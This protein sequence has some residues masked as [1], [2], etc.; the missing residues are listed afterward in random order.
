MGRSQAAAWAKGTAAAA[1]ICPHFPPSV[2]ASIRHCSTSSGSNTGAAASSFAALLL[3]KHDVAEAPP[4]RLSAAAK[5]AASHPRID[6]EISGTEFL[7]LAR[8]CMLVCTGT[9][10]LFQDLWSAICKRAASM[11]KALRLRDAVLLLSAAARVQQLLRHDEHQQFSPQ[12]KQ[13]LLQHSRMVQVAVTALARGLLR[14][15]QHQQLAAK[16]HELQQ[17][18]EQDHERHALTAPLLTAALHAFAILKLQHPEALQQ[19]ASAAMSLQV[20]KFSGYDVTAFCS[21]LLLAARQQQDP[22]WSLDQL[23][24]VSLWLEETL[25]QQLQ[26]QNVAFQQKNARLMLQLETELQHHQKQQQQQQHP[27]SQQSITLAAQQITHGLQLL[28][29][30]SSQELA[31][32]WERLPNRQQINLS[33]LLHFFLV[34]RNKHRPSPLLPLMLQAALLQMKEA[35]LRLSL[36]GLKKSTGKPLY[37]DMQPLEHEQSPATDT[38]AAAAETNRVQP[39]AFSLSLSSCRD[40]AGLAASLQL[41]DQQELEAAETQLQLVEEQEQQVAL[42][43]SQAISLLLHRI[44]WNGVL[45]SFY[46]SIGNTED[47]AT[48]AHAA[49]LKATRAVAGGA[50]GT[51][52]KADANVAAAATTAAAALMAAPPIAQ[53]LLLAADHSALLFASGNNSSD[54]CNGGSTNNKG[55]RHHEF[56][57]AAQIANSSSKVYQRTAAARC[58]SVAVRPAAIPGKVHLPLAAVLQLNLQHHWSQLSPEQLAMCW[59]FFAQTAAAASTAAGE[60]DAAASPLENS[61]SR[62]SEYSSAKSFFEWQRAAG[63]L[64]ATLAVGPLRDGV[65]SKMPSVHLSHVAVYL[66]AIATLYNV[67]NNQRGAPIG[68]ASVAHDDSLSEFSGAPL[69][70]THLVKQLQETSEGLARRLMELLLQQKHHQL[71]PQQQQE[72]KD[73]VKAVVVGELLEGPV[74]GPRSLGHIITAVAALERMAP[75]SAAATVAAAARSLLQQKGQNNVPGAALSLKH[76]GV[77]LHALAKFQLRDTEILARLCRCMADPLEQLRQQLQQQQHP[78]D[79]QRL[80]LLSGQQVAQVLLSLSQLSFTPAHLLQSRGVHTPEQEDATVAFYQSMFQL[81]QRPLQYESLQRDMELHSAVNCLHALALSD[82][83]LTSSVVSCGI[84]SAKPWG[85]AGEEGSPVSAVSTF[86]DLLLTVVRKHLLPMVQQRQG[87][88]QHRQPREAESGYCTALKTT[89][90]QLPAVHQQLTA[91]AAAAAAPRHTSLCASLHPE[92]QVFLQKLQQHVCCISPSESSGSAQEP[93]SWL[94]VQGDS[95]SAAGAPPH[96]AQSQARLTVE[97]SASMQQE[98]HERWQEAVLIA[99]AKLLALFSE[100]AVRAAFAVAS[101]F[102][103]PTQARCSFGGYYLDILAELPGG[104]VQQR[105]VAVEADGGSHFLFD[106]SMPQ[107]RALRVQQHGEGHQPEG[108]WA[109]DRCGCI[110]SS[111][112]VLKHRLLRERGLFVVSVSAAEWKAAV[113]QSRICCWRKSCT[114]S[115]QSHALEASADQASV[116]L[117]SS[118][119]APQTVRQCHEKSGTGQ[120]NRLCFCTSVAF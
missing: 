52:A 72:K 80:L 119:P 99:D 94:L 81:L 107:P 91:A 40:L 22:G 113:R 34:L 1:L 70:H 108:L 103:W 17:D 89:L 69:L 65:A 116:C 38:A 117:G 46:A 51:E 59:R 16:K 85:Q 115:F 98:Q 90:A 2:A 92:N 55:H 42:A 105:H 54:R 106:C 31:A 39:F 9:V 71:H 27:E 5:A 82:F 12:H 110:Y 62:S 11:E 102:L 58:S 56:V 23:R 67:T 120:L 6:C 101:C 73:F 118:R 8:K 7:A 43:S 95:E 3:N 45:T 28:L 19:I 4:G 35:R 36:L 25:L 109:T 18:Q 10:Y 48:V 111:S 37:L 93:H 66:E 15:Q 97:V 63:L 114:D 60:A 68:L 20:R 50:A 77:L 75:P 41:L 84:Q 26:R 88:Q 53:L 112:T 29:Q 100:A 74:T 96:L 87:Q 32:A 79:Q 33:A 13:L 83:S 57:S 64:L 61:Q 21:A 44:S 47:P 104:V 76:C 14:Q 30:E 49:T 78:Q 86:F 24:A